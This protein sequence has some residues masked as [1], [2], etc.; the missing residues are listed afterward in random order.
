MTLPAFL[1][2]LRSLPF[3]SPGMVLFTVIL[4]TTLPLADT[5]SMNVGRFFIARALD[6]SPDET[7]W[8]TAGYSLFVALGIPLSYRL[9]GF[10]E[11]RDLYALAT[12][13]FMGG[14][15]VS[16]LAHTMPSMMVGRALQG[17]SGGVLIPLSLALINEAFPPE[18]LARARAL[19]AIGNAI[20]VSAGP[21]IGGLLVDTLGWRWTMGIHLP[22]GFLTLLFAAL[23]LT[24][25]P[26][27]ESVPFD[28]PGWL[29]FSCAAFFFMYT[30]MEGERFGWHSTPIFLT[31][32]ACLVSFFSYLLWATLHDRPIVPLTL[33]RS[34][35]YILLSVANFLRSTA[36]FGRLYLLPLYLEI[37][38]HFQSHQAGMIIFMG[39]ITEI[40]IPVFALLVSSGE[41]MPLWSLM[42]GGSLL[43]ALA[44]TAYLSLPANVY[45]L[46]LVLLPQMLFGIGVALTQVSLQPLVADTLPAPLHRVGMV[47]QLMVQFLGGMFGVVWARH[48]LDNISPAYRLAL[49]QSSSLSHL[50]PGHALVRRLSGAFAYNLTF[51]ILGGVGIL[52]AFAALALP[53]RTLFRSRKSEESATGPS[54]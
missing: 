32:L 23:S 14:S 4:G 52:A 13:V 26:R 35:G 34:T 28:L 51:L 31:T 44:N 45:S 21:T 50:A 19:F 25:H 43:I 15:V 37:F 40:L 36:M 47:F 7:R 1:R 46:S 27:Q 39:V 20:A 54:Q 42:A 11:E 8:L 41:K 33:F 17:L 3:H 38:Y 9:R 16:M 24:N 12:A 18:K 5:T 2:R 53:L 48:L 22:I 30:T 10:F 6:S 49:S 29:L